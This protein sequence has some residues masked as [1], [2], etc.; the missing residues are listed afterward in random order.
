MKRFWSA[1][2][3][4]QTQAGFTIRLDDKPLRLPGGELILTSEPLA[5]AIAAEWA[6]AGG[7]AAQNFT[8]DDLP[9]TRLAI[10]ARDRIGPHRADI[11]RQLTAYGLNDLLCYRAETPPALAVQEAEAWDPWLDWAAARFQAQLFIG[12]GISPVSQPPATAAA[13]TAAL[14]ALTDQNL[15]ALGVIT[16]ALGSLVLGLALAEAALTP[17]AACDLAHLDELF[18]AQ[19]WGHDPQSAARRA[20]ILKDVA[21][22]TRFMMLCRA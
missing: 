3:V 13:F 10:T 15:A 17:A 16:P 9:L 14:D 6:T 21:V 12:T 11:I 1:T 5:Q 22:S 2:H 20:D 4:T 7:A 8:P 18:Q 19:Q